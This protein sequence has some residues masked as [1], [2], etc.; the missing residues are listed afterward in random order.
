ME[1]RQ[2]DMEM[3]EPLVDTVMADVEVRPG[4]SSTKRLKTLWMKSRVVSW[5]HGEIPVENSLLRQVSSLLRRLPA[6]ES[7]KFQDDFL[8]EYNDTLLISY[9]AMFTD[10]SSTMNDLVDKINVAYEGVIRRGGRTAFI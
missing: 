5:N 3:M 7:Q 10:C 4:D 9:L 1:H 2:P 8:M 6:I